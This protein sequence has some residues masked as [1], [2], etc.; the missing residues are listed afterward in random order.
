[1]GK[2]KGGTEI[3]GRMG[4]IGTIGTKG[5]A[6]FMRNV[7]YICSGIVLMYLFLVSILS[8][9]TLGYSLN[10]GTHTF[11]RPD[12]PVVHFMAVFALMGILFWLRKTTV[13]RDYDKAVW[14]VVGVWGFAAALWALCCM[15]LPKDDPANVLLAA[16]QMR[17]YNFSSFTGEGYL[18]IWAGNRS[19]ALFFYL[20]SFPLGVDNYALLRLLNVAAMMVVFLLLYKIVGE[21]WGK[22]KRV[23]FW[24]VA[25]CACFAP[26]LLYT[27]FIYGDIYGLCLAVAAVFAQMIYLRG[28]V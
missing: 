4:T 26:V 28:G 12:Y 18:N 7:V 5:L 14:F 9:C 23:A 1:M 19:L 25:L 15:E 16:R 21:L 24:T 3:M 22:G 11:F 13:C 2:V 20:L 17:E 8:T 10:S 6:N 27:T